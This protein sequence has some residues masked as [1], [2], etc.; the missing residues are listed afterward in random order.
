MLLLLKIIF[1]NGRP[2]LKDPREQFGREDYL[3]LNSSLI[4]TILNNHPMSH[5]LLLFITL[6]STVVEIFA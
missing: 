6:M 3:S 2:S 1:S 4:K 5:S